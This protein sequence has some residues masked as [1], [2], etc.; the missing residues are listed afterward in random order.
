VANKIDKTR[1]RVE[2]ETFSWIYCLTILKM[3]KFQFVIMIKY[4][5]QMST[6]PLRNT[7]IALLAEHHLL[8]A[9][10][11]VA[12]I[13]AQGRQVNKTSVYRAIDKLQAEQ[14]V[15][16]HNLLGNELLYEL[17]DD[18]HD[19]LV[20]VACGKIATTDCHVNIPQKVDDFSVLHHHLTLFGM[21]HECQTTI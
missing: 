15:C 12:L 7:I 1:P 14:K 5:G 4:I 20:C 19:H 10:E 11:I 3:R 16:R 13:H 8:S 21:C 17:S 9:P 2:G 6:E 18:H